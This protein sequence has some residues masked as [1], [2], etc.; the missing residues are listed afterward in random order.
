VRIDS[1][2]NAVVQPKPEQSLPPLRPLL[3]D[4]K[5]S[6]PGA[7]GHGRDECDEQRKQERK[8]SKRCKCGSDADPQCDPHNDRGYTSMADPTRNALILLHELPPR[9]PKRATEALRAR[10]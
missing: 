1:V 10:W 7:P 8:V 6:I 2:T 9:A 3:L 4:L 5:R